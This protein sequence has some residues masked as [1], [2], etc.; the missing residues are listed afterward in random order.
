M[1]LAKQVP[2][3]YLRRIG[4]QSYPYPVRTSI[5]LLCSVSMVTCGCLPIKMRCYTIT[6][7]DIININCP[8]YA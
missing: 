1:L 7:A 3:I 4:L 2:I 8:S 6:N 5:R